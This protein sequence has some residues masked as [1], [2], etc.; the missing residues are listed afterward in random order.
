MHHGG[1]L[2][3]L[4]VFMQ[5]YRSIISELSASQHKTAVAYRGSGIWLVSYSWSFIGEPFNRFFSA[6]AGT[7]EIE[8]LGMRD[9]SWSDVLVK[10]VGR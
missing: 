2:R 8:C 5:P 6:S 4:G 7:I 9:Q 10:V 1:D 3:A